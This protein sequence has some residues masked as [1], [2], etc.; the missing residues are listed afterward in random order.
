M[1]GSMAGGMTWQQWQGTVE[2]LLQAMGYHV[3]HFRP[4]MN[5][6]GNWRT[7]VSGD[8][9]GFP[10]FLAIHKET[11]RLIVAECKTGKAKLSP[12]QVTWLDYFLLAGAETYEWHP[13]E[14]DSIVELIRGG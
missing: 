1:E 6:A 14:Y 2:Q 13:D 10:D 4:A 5:Q 3:A 11:G 12:E 9:K 8:G 7:P